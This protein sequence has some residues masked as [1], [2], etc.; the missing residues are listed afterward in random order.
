MQRDGGRPFFPFIFGFFIQDK[1]RAIGRR[2]L[3]IG[4]DGKRDAA[5]DECLGGFGADSREFLFRLL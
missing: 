1:N 5:A 4:R 2:V 3:K